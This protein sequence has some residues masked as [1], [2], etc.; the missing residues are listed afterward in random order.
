MVQRLL[1]QFLEKDFRSA[2][3][4]E[5]Y[6][7]KVGAMIMEKGLTLKDQVRRILEPYR[8]LQT[9]LEIMERSKN[10]E[11]ELALKIRLDLEAL[12]P[13]N[14]LE[15]YDS[16]RLVHLPRYLK[17]MRIRTQRGANNAEKHRLK[18]ARIEEF[19]AWLQECKENLSPHASGEKREALDVFRWMIEEFKVSVFAQELKT[20]FPVSVK[21]LEERKKQIQRMV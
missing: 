5:R 17:A 1:V 14:F 18:N 21:R 11:A 10:A 13:P 2:A 15:L 19:A 4:I 20:P 9:A 3:E 7:E 16:E 8:E 12:L 6:A